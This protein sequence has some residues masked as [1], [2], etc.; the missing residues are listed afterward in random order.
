VRIA[1]DGKIGEV[2]ERLAGPPRSKV[3]RQVVAP[4]DLSHFHVEQMRGVK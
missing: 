3:A 1:A 4:Q 2:G